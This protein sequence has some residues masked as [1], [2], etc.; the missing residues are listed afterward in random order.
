MVQVF[1]VCPTSLPDEYGITNNPGITGPGERATV[2]IAGMM[3]A[4]PVFL[5]KISTG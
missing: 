5:E 4:S 2:S 3:P 1:L